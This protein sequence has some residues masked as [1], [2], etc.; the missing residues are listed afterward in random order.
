MASEMI[1]SLGQPALPM[2]FS[3]I[4]VGGRLVRNRIVMPSMHTGYC[5]SDGNVSSRLLGYLEPRVR[6]IGLLVV[7]QAA[8]HPAGRVSAPNQL[9]FWDESHIP[10]VRLIA[11]LAHGH[12]ALA[13]IQISHSGRQAREEIIGSRP[14]AP[15]AVTC[16]AFPLAPRELTADEIPALQELYVAA[17]GRAARAGLDG[18]ELHAAHGFLMNQFLS[19][20]F[21]RREDAYGGDTSRRA[22]FVVEVIEGI[23]ARLGRNFLI[24]LRLSI[25]EG[26]EGGL[27]I[28]ESQRLAALLADAGIDALHCSAGMTFNRYLYC[29]PMGIRP[30]YNL[31]LAAAMKEAVGIPVIAAGRLNDPRLA[32]KALQEGVADMVSVGRG[33]ISDPDLPEKAARGDFGSIRFCIGCNEACGPR[34]A[35]CMIN[36]QAGRELDLVVAPA[37]KPRSVLVIG[38]GPAGLEAAL[39]AASSGHRV[40]LFERAGRLGGQL[41]VGAIPPAKQELMV[42]IEYAESQLRRMGVEV[43]LGETASAETVARLAPDCVILATGSSP[44]WPSIDGIDRAVTATAVDVLNGL[45][46]VGDEVVVVGGGETGC[47][48]ADFL[49]SLGRRVTVVEM[50]PVVA[51]EVVAEQRHYLMERLQA[52][53]VQLLVSARATEYRDRKLVVEGPDGVAELKADTVVLAVGSRSDRQLVDQLRGVVQDVRVIGDAEH[54]GNAVDAIRRGFEE[55]C[56]V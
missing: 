53:G 40:R 35:G 21:N 55:G 46:E 13:I 41:A 34:P 39:V 16:E 52:G 11:E 24:Q 17:A 23:R 38:G 33:L 18:V 44:V 43:R 47:E 7:E 25:V 22:R 51:R 4:R 36:P 30:G 32:E 42:W 54:P 19:P 10:G 49:A 45:A 48:T 27:D 31:P 8:V 3:A 37:A 20:Y 2:L 50:L 9:A 56:A 14:V 26:V 12:G 15:S 6:H 28:P 5:H 1:G 29:A